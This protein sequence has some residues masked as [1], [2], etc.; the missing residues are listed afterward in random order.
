MAKP[1][2]PPRET[3]P[4]LGAD[5]VIRLPTEN[6]ERAPSLRSEPPVSGDMEPPSNL[7]LV[8]G[9]VQA[10]GP[11]MTAVVVP[12]PPRALSKGKDGPTTMTGTPGATYVVLKTARACSRTGGGFPRHYGQCGIL[13]GH[14]RVRRRQS[15][16][17][18]RDRR[19]H[20]GDGQ[21]RNRPH[22]GRPRRRV[23]RPVE[24]TSAEA[25]AAEHEPDRHGL[26]HRTWTPTSR[27]PVM[28]LSPTGFQQST[29]RRWN[30]AGTD[31][32][33]R[34]MVV[35][36]EQMTRLSLRRSSTVTCATP[37][38]TTSSKISRWT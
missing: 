1:V 9:H 37:S 15:L 10:G 24:F 21:R 27:D 22:R 2:S 23:G 12:N 29:R 32:A 26:R 35:R 16:A 11:W 38:M 36:A 28:T 33:P 17:E 19:A 30:G 34:E 14:R 6:R 25:I 3:R 13:R 18:I 20:R 31:L 4:W 8:P 5:A 7:A